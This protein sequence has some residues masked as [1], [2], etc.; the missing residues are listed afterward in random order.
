MNFKKFF[1]FSF[2]ITIIFSNNLF[3]KENKI[4][5]KV[6][7]EIITSLDILNETTYLKIV[8]EE[9]SKASKFQAL[10][11]A[12]NSLIKEK[13]KEIELVSKFKKLEID[14][15]QLNQFLLNFFK[16]K[17]VNSLEELNL[18]LIQNKLDLNDIK[19]KITID[20]YWNRFIYLKYKDNIKIDINN[21]KQ[22]LSK[23]KIQKEYLISEILFELKEGEKLN[24]KTD[25]IKKVIEEK[26]FNYASLIYSIS[27]TSKDGG[28]LG[29]IKESSLNKK[30]LN[31]IKNANNNLTS[32][33]V[34]PGGFLILKIKDIREIEKNLDIEKEVEL[35]V[36]QKTNE[37]LEQFSNIY[38]NKLKKNFSINEL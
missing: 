16:K 32:T 23:K 37:Q 27:D 2:V 28:K 24:E 5:F 9:F 25:K 20:L 21:I 14:E 30:I 13:I 10:D 34:L 38:F 3:S 11:I 15:K 17:G 8:S 33:I 6:N 12:K 1:I 18:F 4:L 26:G 19:K 29:W 7:N 31:E 22:K 36:K 35:I